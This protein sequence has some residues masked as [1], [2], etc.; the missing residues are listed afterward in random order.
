MG[1]LSRTTRQSLVQC[2]HAQAS[3][4]LQCRLP[5][6]CRSGL[7]YQPQQLDPDQLALMRRIDEPYT[8]HPFYGSRQMSR[9]LRREGYPAGTGCGGWCARWAWRRLTAGRGRASR[10]RVTGSFRTCCEIWQSSGQL[11]QLL[12]RGLQIQ[13]LP[14]TAQGHGPGPLIRQV[15]RRVARLTRSGRRLQPHFA[16]SNRRLDWLA[17]AWLC[18]EPPG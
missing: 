3:L 9:H 4:R 13:M 16:C 10:S 6:A 5:G 8:A 14:E 1:A 18:L 17:Q 12:M 15:V 11:A 7:Y 2:D